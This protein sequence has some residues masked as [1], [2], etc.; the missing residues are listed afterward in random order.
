[1]ARPTPTKRP[2]TPRVTKAVQRKRERRGLPPHEVADPTPR[3]PRARG[4]DERISVRREQ[5]LTLRARG[6]SIRV[7]ARELR[8]SP[9]TIHSDVAAELAAVAEQRRALAD[10]VLDLELSRL[11]VLTAAVMAHIESGSLQAIDTALKVGA[12]R[13]ALLGLDKRPEATDSSDA[14]VRF[15][16]ESAERAKHGKAGA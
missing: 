11:D 14:F 15:L 6:L 4:A 7:I 16:E 10:K 13:A 3:R 8:A 1:M 5:A 12:R 2:T 9:A